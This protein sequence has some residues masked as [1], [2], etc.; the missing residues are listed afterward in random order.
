VAFDLA[1]DHRTVVRAHFGRYAEE[2][3]TS[4]YDFLD[5]LSQSPFTIASVAAPRMFVQPR[6]L[7][8]AAQASIDPDLA[9][10]YDQEYLVGADRQLPGSFSVRAQFIGRDFRD[11]IGFT[12]PARTWVAAQAL[13]RGPDGKA[14]TADDG[15]PIPIYLD[16]TPGLSAPLL[17]NPAAA[18][19]RSHAAQFVLSKR[20]A[21]TFELQASY[22]WSR[23]VGSYNNA[24]FANAANADL[25][26]NGV[27]VNPNRQINTNGRTPQDF[28]HD[29]LLV[30]TYQLAR[31]G[32]LSLG[33]VYRYQSGRPWARSAG[34]G[35]VPPQAETSLIFVEPRGT[36]EL[37]AIDS[38][39]LRLE[40]TWK[41]A[42]RAGTVGGFV[43]LF[44][45]GNQGVALRVNNQSGP[46]LGVPTQWLD[47]RTVRAGLRLMF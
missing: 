21:Q 43:D 4:F 6:Q 13:D 15:G 47:P 33:G 28:T 41:P 20:Y 25:G 1:G 44:N 34:A 5:P 23:T 36:R 38:F 45:A 46:N 40:K 11:A 26:L 14:G 7:P 16:Q 42:K 18:Y 27:F 12:D 8:T 32:G 37:P 10:P 29:V 9:Y 39:D 35:S 2:L 24:A 17:T 19:R 3:V 30:G 22:T 31:W